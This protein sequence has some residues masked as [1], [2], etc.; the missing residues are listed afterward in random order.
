[1][2]LIFS[3]HSLLLQE[4]FNSEYTTYTHY[5][6]RKQTKVEAGE[7]ISEAYKEKLAEI[8]KTKPINKPIMNVRVKKGVWSYEKKKVEV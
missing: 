8:Q 6:I 1:M 5:R 4:P 3:D 7:H 2:T